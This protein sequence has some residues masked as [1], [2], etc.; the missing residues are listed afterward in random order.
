MLWTY[1]LAATTVVHA[2]ADS[3]EGREDIQK[4]RQADSSRSYSFL[5]D[6]LFL[7]NQAT[8]VKLTGVKKIPILYFKSPYRN[9]GV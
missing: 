3:S 8:Y 9:F 2:A 5:R 6:T 7:G 4:S 1:W